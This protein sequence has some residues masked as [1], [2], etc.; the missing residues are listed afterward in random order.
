MAPEVQTIGTVAKELE[1]VVQKKILIALTTETQTKVTSLVVL[2][3][4]AAD[5]EV[6]SPDPK[7]ITAIGAMNLTGKTTDSI[8]ATYC[9]TDIKFH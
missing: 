9:I 1:S 8:S 7:T 4:K 2:T 3:I 6:D 5:L